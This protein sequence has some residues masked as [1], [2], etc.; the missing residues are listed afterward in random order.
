MVR[1]A[2]AAVIV[3]SKAQAFRATFK[4]YTSRFTLKC[5]APAG[6][7]FDAPYWSTRQE[8]LTDALIQRAILERLAVGFFTT[9]S[10]NILGLDM[11]DHRLQR[12]WT[13]H[14]SAYL[15]AIYGQAVAKLGTYP[16]ILVMSPHG[17]HA[18]WIL[19]QRLP[20][21][22]LHEAARARLGK[23]PV[24]I[25]PTPTQSLRVPAE[26][27]LLDPETLQPLPIPF[28]LLLSQVPVYH[29]AFLM[30]DTY[31]PET[32]R[33]SLQSRKS[34]SRILRAIPRLE[35]VEAEACPLVDGATNEAFLHLCLAYRTAGLTVEEAMYRFG[36]VLLR[37]PGYSG[38]LR[39]PKRL[40]QRIRCEYRHNAYQ[41]QPRIVQ[42]SL[43][44]AQIAED[45][46]AR[47]PWA[48]QRRQPVRRFVEGI[49]RWAD[50]QDEIWENKAQLALFDYLYPFYRVNR[51]AGFYPL[52]QSYLQK[53]HHRYN[54]LLPW[55]CSEGFLS[56]LVL[57]SPF[58]S[59]SSA[60]PQKTVVKY[61]SAVLPPRGSYSTVLGVCK[62]YRI[63]RALLAS[64]QVL[65]LQE[66]AG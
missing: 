36:I 17:F 2:A 12:V 45:L 63:E 50:W 3:R 44:N 24:E 26:R 6:E 38:D 30:D 29:P 61:V 59:G 37:S 34:R 8:P 27:R 21:L 10:P 13:A 48:A 43:F 35:Q 57:G 5:K 18:Y 15:L 55:L 58:A 25:K 42:G 33:S 41:P 60:K 47:Q 65:H 53:Q 11:D 16:S 22:V 62:Y 7:F 32:V 23:L 40:E 9:F 66:A 51:R 39:S 1:Q 46:A 28:E 4:P 64:R 56:P 19:S 14:R 49:L 31:L 54:E 20:V 52:P